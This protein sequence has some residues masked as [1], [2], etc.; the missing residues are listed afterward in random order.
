MCQEEKPPLISRSRF[1]ANG[2]RSSREELVPVREASKKRTPTRLGR[3]L[4][5]TDSFGTDKTRTADNQQC[6]EDGGEQLTGT[7]VVRYPRQWVE[8]TTGRP[9]DGTRCE[10]VLLE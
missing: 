9:V 7:R 5:D 4:G 10:L 2:Q 8:G 3:L 6:L 1:S